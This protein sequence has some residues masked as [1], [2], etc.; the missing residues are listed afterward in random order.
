MEKGG[1]GKVEDGWRGRV[2]LLEQGENPEKENQKSDDPDQTES[3][4]QLGAALGGFLRV[5]LRLRL[6][7]GFFRNAFFSR[8]RLCQD[9]V[10]PA[11]KSKSV[12]GRVG[13]GGSDQIGMKVN[14]GPGGRMFALL[15]ALI[16]SIFFKTSSFCSFTAL[17]AI[18]F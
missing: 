4:D 9:Q 7:R 17:L 3:H 8:E 2:K 16:A 1:R 11:G 10:D 18:S 12:P 5:G 6:Q 15:S 13:L 14:L